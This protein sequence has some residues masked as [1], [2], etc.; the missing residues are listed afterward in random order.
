[1]SEPRTLPTEISRTPFTRNN[2]DAVSYPVIYERVG[3]APYALYAECTFELADAEKIPQ[4]IIKNK[5]IRYIFISFI[6]S[7]SL[8]YPFL[9]PINHI[10][11]LFHNFF[12]KAFYKSIAKGYNSDLETPLSFAARFKAS[13]LSSPAAI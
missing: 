6:T 11:R 8:S 13:F 3:I 12:T 9:L 2:L 4:M 7:L 5:K 1:M 10:S